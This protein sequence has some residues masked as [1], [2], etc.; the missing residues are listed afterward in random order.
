[1]REVACLSEEFFAD[2]GADTCANG[3][4]ESE[5]SNNS[6][7]SNGND[8]TPQRRRERRERHGMD[9]GQTGD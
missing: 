9:E 3:G 2:R 8:H 1:V 5:G 6:D 7:D 4:N